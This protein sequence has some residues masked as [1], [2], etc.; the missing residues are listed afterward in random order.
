MRGGKLNRPVRLER[1][2]VTRAGDGGEIESWVLESEPF[3]EIEFLSGTDKFESDRRYSR[4]AAM[5]RIRFREGVTPKMRV[6]IDGEAWEIM[7]VHE[8]QRRHRLELVCYA[9]EVES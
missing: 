4:S 2:E 7:A 3:A 9:T 5:V 1:L 8:I 6:V